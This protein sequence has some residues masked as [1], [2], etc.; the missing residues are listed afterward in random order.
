M[1]DEQEIKLKIIILGKTEVG[2]TCILNRYFNNLFSYSSLPTIGMECY[3]KNYTINSKNVTFNFYDTAGQEKYNSIVT[4]YLRNAN[5]VILV[6]DITKEDSF[7][8]IK[9]WVDQLK[10]NNDTN[11]IIL[12][13]NKSDLNTKRVISKEEGIKLAEKLNC[14][15][16]EVSALSNENISEAI[17]IIVNITYKN[18]LKEKNKNNNESII[19]DMR[20]T[21]KKK[22]C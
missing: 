11:S 14:D 5:G 13:G 10:D 1:K 2:K 4:N 9:M 12:L 21:N 16:F 15:F 22:C 19:V 8:K 7:E 20:N 18:Y 6:Y 3:T 17:E